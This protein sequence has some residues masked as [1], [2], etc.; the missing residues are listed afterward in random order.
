MVL[1]NKQLIFYLEVVAATGMSVFVLFFTRG[2][3]VVGLVV[4]EL[5]S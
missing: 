1:V 2:F 4:N 3:K 5:I